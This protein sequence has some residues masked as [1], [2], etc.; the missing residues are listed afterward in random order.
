MVDM[1]QS[2]G[3]DVITTAEVLSLIRGELR[4][5]R[6]HYRGIMLAIR[7]GQIEADED[8]NLTDGNDCHADKWV[9]RALNE[10]AMENVAD[11]CRDTGKV[12]DRDKVQAFIRRALIDAHYEGDDQPDSLP[13]GCFDY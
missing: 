3:R 10:T 1:N 13:A 8:M 5:V 6:A 11:W 4:L 2:L 9:F 7:A 12:Y